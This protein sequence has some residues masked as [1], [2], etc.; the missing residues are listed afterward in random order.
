MAKAVFVQKGDNIDYKAESAVEY[1]DVVPMASCI[2]VALEPI[3]N[4]KTG[5]V[6]L[7]GVYE[8][9]A[10]ADLGTGISISP[11]DAVYWN[12]SNS[13]IDKDASGV[14][15]G[16]AVTAK[17]GTSVRVKLHPFPVAAS[18]ES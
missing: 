18:G 10:A 16:I 1:M 5:T 14:P 6:S 3:A 9:P 7:T 2:G 4:G 15:A 12:T 13:N 17:T 8:L 11:G